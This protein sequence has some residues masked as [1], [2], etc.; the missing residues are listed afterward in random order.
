MR[1]TRREEILAHAAKLFSER[2]I[3]ATTV[4]DIAD[5]VGILSGSLYHYFDS[6]DAIANEIVV[7]FLDDL[8]VRYES[9]IESGG[10]ARERLASMVSVSFATAVDH[11]YATEVYQGEAIL[12]SQPDDAPITI[13][14]RKAHD[15]WRTAIARGLADGEFRADIDPEQFHRLLRESVW[16]TVA[17]YRPQLAE[18]ADELERNLITVFLD[19]FAARGDGSAPAPRVPA[20]SAPVDV[21]SEVSEVAE[22][23]SDVD[24]LK[25]AIRDL[26]SVIRELQAQR[27]S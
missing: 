17:Q 14:V 3:S 15:Y 16:S 19:G 11:P 5:E 18:R 8:N 6:K 4:R 25:S 2:G 12:S 21:P 27:P 23:R 24:E 9:S 22:L 13:A 20:V 10:S 26:G 7:R 1:S